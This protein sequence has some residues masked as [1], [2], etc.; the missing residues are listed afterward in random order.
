MI[1]G[2]H[3]RLA[4]VGE[5]HIAG[6]ETELPLP[7]TVVGG[8]ALFYNPINRTRQAGEPVSEVCV[9][10][11]LTATQ[12]PRSVSVQLDAPATECGDSALIE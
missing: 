2:L 3:S 9:A 10:A 7:P 4:G 12:G 5:S 8:E 11:T 1:S 6:R